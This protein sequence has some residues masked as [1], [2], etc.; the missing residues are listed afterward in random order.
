MIPELE[1]VV[2][3]EEPEVV[4]QIEEPVV[5]EEPKVDLFGEINA[6]P[7]AF[8]EITPVYITDK[9]V[10][11]G[12]LNKGPIKNEL[13]KS[14]VKI[15]PKSISRFVVALIII[16]LIL[17]VVG[18]TIFSLL[19]IKPTNVFKRMLI[20]IGDVLPEKNT[21]VTEIK[22]NITY[23]SNALNLVPVNFDL[24]AYIDDNMNTVASVDVSSNDTS[25]ASLNVNKDAA[26]VYIYDS[27][28]YN[29]Y[30]KTDSN[31][32]DNYDITKGM[33]LIKNIGEFKNIVNEFKS[34]LLDYMNASKFKSEYVTINYNG[35]DKGAKKI[36]YELDNLDSKE[37]VSTIIYE[38]KKDS[39]FITSYAKLLNVTNEDVVIKL[40]ALLNDS[41]N[42]DNLKIQM[43]IYTNYI[44][45][46][47]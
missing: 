35:S 38:L 47:Y 1:P 7:D 29:G 21:G 24:N 16:L 23:D 41:I 9:Y 8:D 43:N 34:N 46:K 14:K 28:L 25:V 4:E 5:E 36:S 17:T 37:F 31:A 13:Y 33:R 32:L 6:L 42:D 22:S 30:F 19:Y 45:N 11:D 15:S 2:V 26:G 40:N 39:S 20:N 12:V 44:T 18:G 10:S 27:N 3:E